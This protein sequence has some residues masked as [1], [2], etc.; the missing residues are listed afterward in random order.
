MFVGQEGNSASLRGGCLCQCRQSRWARSKFI[1]SSGPIGY[2]LSMKPLSETNPYLRD[3]QV[4]RRLLERNARDSSAFEGARGIK[5]SGVQGPEA[6]TRKAASKK[7][8]SSS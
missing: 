1:V 7:A 5:P 6:P 4:R 3:P 2:N 8:A